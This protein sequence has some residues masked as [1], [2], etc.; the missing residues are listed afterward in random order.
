MRMG[1]DVRLAAVAAV[2]VAGC[3][4][5][6]AGEGQLAA[7]AL[8]PATTTTAAPTS[9]PATTPAPTTTAAPTTPSKPPNTIQAPFAGT[10]SGP[11][12]QPTGVIPRWTA[13]LSLPAGRPAGTF[14]IAGVCRGPAL[15]VS[16]AR[17][18]LVLREIISSDPTSRCAASGTITLVPSG[19]RLRMTW[20]DADHPTNKA[21]GVL[22]KA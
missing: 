22:T 3:T 7:E 2:L 15:V 1:V 13:V 6:V 5:T 4:T 18:K 14:S 11:V 19:G 9:A 20:V 17:T 16:A 10:W 21:S 8:L 12:R